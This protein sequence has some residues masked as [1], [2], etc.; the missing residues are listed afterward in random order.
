MKRLS[1]G[2]KS[3]RKRK[4][5]L[6]SLLTVWLWTE[7]DYSCQ[8]HQLL[9]VQQQQHIHMSITQHVCQHQALPQPWTHIIP[10][11]LIPQGIM[12]RLQEHHSHCSMTLCR[13]SGWKSNT[14]H[15][16]PPSTFREQKDL[17]SLWLFQQFGKC[18]RSWGPCAPWHS[19]HQPGTQISTGSGLHFI[20]WF[21]L[22]S[23]NWVELEWCENTPPLQPYQCF[24]R[25]VSP[26]IS[27]HRHILL[28]HE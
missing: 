11:F 18:G 28:I 3:L 19:K 22:S 21:L 16:H 7:G 5:G 26:G 8:Q 6:S 24:Q 14:G 17:G 9:P 27:S 2:Y 25:T 23:Y 20:M 10:D 12:G 13:S 15:A 1:K 4:L